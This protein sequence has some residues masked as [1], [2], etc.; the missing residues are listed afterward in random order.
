MA[1]TVIMTKTHETR[2]VI[3]TILCKRTIYSLSIWYGP[4]T[5]QEGVV[6]AG[7]YQLQAGH[8]VLLPAIR[9]TKNTVLRRTALLKL[10]NMQMVMEYLLCRRTPTAEIKY[11]RKKTKLCSILSFG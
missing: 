1:V 5:V 11:G 8:R 3:A 9:P 10:M 2:C 6:L 7:C 4:Q